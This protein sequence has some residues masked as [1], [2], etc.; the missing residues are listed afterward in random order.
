MV[1]LLIF[2]TA[3][4]PSFHNVRVAENYRPMLGMRGSDG[5]QSSTL[6]SFE[7]ILTFAEGEDLADRL[8]LGGDAL[9]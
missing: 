2:R 9:N 3:G 7:L 5:T 1:N 6:F 8:N 4:P